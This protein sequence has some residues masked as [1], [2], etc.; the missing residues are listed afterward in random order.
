MNEL[1]MLLE[2]LDEWERAEDVANEAAAIL[3]RPARLQS[4]ELDRLRSL[5]RDAARKLA[6]VGHALMREEP[7]QR[8]SGARS[9]ARRGESQAVHQLIAIAIATATATG[10]L[11]VQG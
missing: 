3:A 2:L 4:S 9:P 6:A 1:R 10:S 7:A 5:Q 11:G 8:A